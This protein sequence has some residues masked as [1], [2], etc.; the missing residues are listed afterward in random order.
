MLEARSPALL[1]SAAVASPRRRSIDID[2]MSRGQQRFEIGNTVPEHH[3]ERNRV[4]GR[5]CGNKMD[6]HL[7]RI[8]HKLEAARSTLKFRF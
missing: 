2:D 1:L 3:H 4:R 5:R 7:H 8:L 6:I